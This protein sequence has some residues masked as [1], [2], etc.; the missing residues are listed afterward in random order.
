MPGDDDVFGLM[1]IQAGDGEA[2]VAFNVFHHLSPEDYE[3]F[4]AS[5]S[6]MRQAF[7]GDLMTYVRY[8]LRE[9]GTV[10]AEIHRLIAE[11]SIPVASGLLRTE[12]RSAV[13]CQTLTFCAALHLFQEHTVTSVQK[14]FGE[15]SKEST[16]LAR[17]F[18]EAYDSSLGY[19]LA[20]RLRNVMIHQSLAAVGLTVR[21]WERMQ[22]SG[23]PAKESQVLISLQRDQFLASR[24]ISAALRREVSGLPGD[25][26]IL[27]MATEALAALEVVHAKAYK[28]IY[29]T[30][31]ADAH[32]FGEL[33]SI[34]A[35]K[36]LPGDDR[37]LVRVIRSNTGSVSSFPYT[38]LSAALFQ[39]AA[40]YAAAME[41]GG[42][43]GEER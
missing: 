11:Q 32:R 28:F 35:A 10:V 3:E 9:M 40:E 36:E 26:D 7:E 16:E 15:E 4:L 2:K 24:K 21:R 12:Y 1:L 39:F 14:H 34:F 27:E 33:D 37:A 31:D 18:S 29:P 20:Y 8:S 19:R 13:I 6:R 41:P 5:A 42:N 38:P 22:D 43:S 23:V 30:I 25:P 17:I